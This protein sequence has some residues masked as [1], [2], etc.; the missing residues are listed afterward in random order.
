MKLA[1]AAFVVWVT[2]LYSQ[3]SPE[4]D[5]DW[6]AMSLGETLRD[7]YYQGASG[8]ERLFVPNAGFS[9]VQKYAGPSPFYLYEMVETL[10]GPKPEPIGKLNLPPELHELTLFVFEARKGELPYEIYAIPGVPEGIPW[11]HARLINLTPYSLAGYLDGEAFQLSP[12]MDDLLEYEGSESGAVSIRIQVASREGESWSP[13]VNTSVG[14]RS[15]TRLTVLFRMDGEK[16]EMISIRET[17]S[18]RALSD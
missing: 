4:Y 5:V 10:E 9:A 11:F 16:I 18:Q 2:P 6:V 13:R 14:V 8:L 3:P 15:N 1:L 17:V 7:V 12:G